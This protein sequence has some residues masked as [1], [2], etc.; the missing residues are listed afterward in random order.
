MTKNNMQREY[1]FYVYIMGSSSGTL[2]VGFTNN[3]LRR[4]EEHKNGKVEGF[5]K[6][7]S[8]NKLLYYEHYGDVR[9]AISREKEIKK[10]RRE[11]KEMLIK[12]LNKNWSDLSK[13]LY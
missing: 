9:L 7:Y 3:L 1:N 12:S 11:K 8:C 5:T 10:W 6:K 13:E 2:Y 4:V